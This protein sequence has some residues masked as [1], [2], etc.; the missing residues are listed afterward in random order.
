MHDTELIWNAFKGALDKYEESKSSRR[1]HSP[2][3]RSSSKSRSGVTTNGVASSVRVVDFVPAP[4]APSRV[5]SPPA[6]PTAVSALSAS[7]A[8][9]SFHQAMAQ[10][11]S[12]Q[13][14]ARRSTRS[15]S[16][17]RS[18]IVA[19]VTRTASPSTASSRTLGIPINGEADIREA[20]RRNM[21][22][23]L[24]MATSYK[25]AMDA[26]AAHMQARGIPTQPEIP[27]ENEVQEAV[28]GS[29]STSF[30]PRGR[31]PQAGKSAIKK[32]RNQTPQNAPIGG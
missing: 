21:D 7:L 5:L 30:A 11:Q 25:Y 17:A 24:D 16:P 27:E 22:Q 2:K 3:R 26:A 8:T 14:S 18:A 9:S 1:I 29:P 20:F 28:V 13:E 19:G 32:A 15:S 12:Q 23:S 4:I 6:A 10:V 31:S